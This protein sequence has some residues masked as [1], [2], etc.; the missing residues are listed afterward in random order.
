MENIGSTISKVVNLGRLDTLRELLQHEPDKWGEY[1]GVLKLACLR[2]DTT[3]VEELLKH[4]QFIASVDES[5]NCTYQTINV[6]LDSTTEHAVKTDLLK[7]VCITLLNSGFADEGWKRVAEIRKELGI[8]R[9]EYGVKA[10]R[11]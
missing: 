2:G 7:K 6:F 10:A 3:I 5:L 8:E 9:R 11:K 4:E 1:G